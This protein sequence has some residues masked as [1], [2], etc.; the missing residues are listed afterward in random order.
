MHTPERFSLKSAGFPIPGS[1]MKIDNPDENGI[2]EICMRGRHIM[3]GYLKN[4]AATKECIDSQGFLHSGDLGKLDAQG[5][6]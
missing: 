4:E 1:D 2:G 6:L 5:F 3:L